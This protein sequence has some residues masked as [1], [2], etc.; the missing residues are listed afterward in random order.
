MEQLKVHGSRK[1][2]AESRLPLLNEK[3]QLKDAVIVDSASRDDSDLLD[4][5]DVNPTDVVEV[6]LQ[7][8]TVIWT[9]VDALREATRGRPSAG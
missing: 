8:G 4:L 1:L 6:E 3:I 7:D 9:R 5:Q 2:G